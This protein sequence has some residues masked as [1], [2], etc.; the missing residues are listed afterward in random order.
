MKIYGGRVKIEHLI[1]NR[2]ARALS[3]AGAQCIDGLRELS[4]VMPRSLVESRS[5]IFFFRRKQICKTR[6]FR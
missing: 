1:K 2:S 5:L 6:I 3:E 4:I